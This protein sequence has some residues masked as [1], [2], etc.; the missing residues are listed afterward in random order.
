MTDDDIFRL[1]L[2]GWIAIVLPI[3][4]YHRIKS[5]T[6]ERLDRRQEGVF[7]FLIRPLGLVFVAGMIA[8][9]L[10]SHW[11]AWSSMGLPSW[12]RWMGVGLAGVAV[13]LLICTFRHLGKN[14]T[15]TVVTRRE[16]TLITTGPYR[17]VRHPFYL[18]LA[19]GAAGFSLMTAHWF[20]AVVG[21]TIFV[22]LA[23]RA[24]KEETNLLKRFGDE[25]RDYVSRTGK[26]WPRLHR[27]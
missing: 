10:D 6:G 21:G 22:L 2:I 5:M 24:R 11:M 25:Y 17:W 3:G 8:Y 27:P 23:M 14:L 13:A 18:V 4:V 20:F 1:V 12:L 26:F 15:D 16:H 7:L 9:I 19:I